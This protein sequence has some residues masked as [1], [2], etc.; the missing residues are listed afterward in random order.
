VVPVYLDGQLITEV[1]SDY[2]AQSFQRQASLSGN[3]GMPG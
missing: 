1:V 3:A 2:Q